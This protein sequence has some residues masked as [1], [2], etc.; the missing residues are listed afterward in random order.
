MAAHLHQ[1]LMADDQKTERQQF[2]QDGAASLASC[3]NED[4][5]RAKS[6]ESLQEAMGITAEDSVPCSGLCSARARAPLKKRPR[7]HSVPPDDTSRGALDTLGPVH[8]PAM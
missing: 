3:C 6:Q 2:R 5:G 1:A 7:T 8:L 4:K